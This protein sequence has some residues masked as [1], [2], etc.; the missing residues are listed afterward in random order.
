MDQVTTSQGVQAHIAEAFGQFADSF[1]RLSDEQLEQPGVEADWS[2]KDILAHI[3]FWHNRMALLIATAQRGEPPATL[4]QLGE[5][6]AAA[7]DRVNAQNYAANADRPLAEVRAAFEQS[8]QHALATVARLSDADLA[9]DSPI[10]QA[11]GG[12]LLALIAGDTYDH[13]AEHL[14]SIQALRP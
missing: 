5:D 6:S 3:T 2:V 7:V 12:S 13:Y 11:L 1:A 4:R 10:C 8:Y 14:P 9:D